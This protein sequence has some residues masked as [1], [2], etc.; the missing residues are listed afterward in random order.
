MDKQ[1]FQDRTWAELLFFLAV[2]LVIGLVGTERFSDQGDVL[3]IVSACLGFV[4][5]ALF[6]TL[7]W[8]KL[9]KR[10]H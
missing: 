7:A 6:L 4:G 10:T 9:Q 3:S 2:S 8:N 1:S 5:V